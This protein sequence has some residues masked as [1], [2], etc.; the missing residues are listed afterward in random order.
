M[1]GR[2]RNSLVL[3]IVVVGLTTLSYVGNFYSP[4]EA[5]EDRPN[6]LFILTDDLAYADIA[7]MPNLQRLLVATG[8]SFDHYYASYAACCPSRASLLR[9]QYAHN[10][11]VKNNSGVNG[12]YAAALANKIENSTVAT[13]LHDAGYRTGY[14]GK[15]LNGYPEGQSPTYI[16]PGWDQWYSAVAGTPYNE[17]NYTMNENGQLVEYGSGLSDY[18]TDVYIGKAESFIATAASSTQ[19][20]FLHL[21]LYPP[22]QPAIPSEQDKNLFP[23]AQVPRTPSFN[24]PDISD[25]PAWVRNLPLL[26]A[27]KIASGDKLY[28][29]RL[30]TLQ[31]VDRG[32]ERLI[33]TLEVRNVLANTY[34]V[35][36]SDNGFHIGQHRLWPPTKVTAYEVDIHLPLI[37]RGPNVKPSAKVS[38]LVGDIDIAPT[39]ATLAGVTPPSFVD[40]RSFASLLGNTKL[41][42]PRRSYLLHHWRVQQLN[43]PLTWIDHIMLAL[44]PA[45]DFHGIR[46]DRYTYVYYPATAERELYDNVADPEQLTNLAATRPDLVAPLHWAFAKL[47][48]CKAEKC[49]TVENQPIF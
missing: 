19:P 45:P 40:G 29:D 21:N 8:T 36:S 38:A 2:S 49:R 3:L 10:T 30:R 44:D 12:G 39:L 41:V 33:T 26:N 25:K 15:Y 4:A 6:I 24:E 9:G 16:P 11:G 35:F 42:W 13:W 22:H 47:L 27:T 34:I 17:Y 46:T 31:A 23:N 48:G 43:N 32:I 20:F 37:I 14:I 5:M 18:G 7:M 28:A 1:E